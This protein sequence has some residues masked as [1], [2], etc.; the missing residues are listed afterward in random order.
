[1]GTRAGCPFAGAIRFEMTLFKGHIYTT[2][3]SIEWCD[4]GRAWSL[5]INVFLGCTVWLI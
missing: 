3:I 1:M 2:E 4:A 5:V